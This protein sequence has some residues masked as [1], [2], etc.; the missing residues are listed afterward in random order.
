MVDKQGPC[1]KFAIVLLGRQIR[2]IIIIIIIIKIIIIIIIIIIR[3]KYQRHFHSPISTN[4]RYPMLYLFST[5]IILKFSYRRT[6]SNT[7]G[8]HF[9]CRFICM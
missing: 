8:Y 9:H 1:G 4:K 6:M 5:S 2:K 3:K 7:N